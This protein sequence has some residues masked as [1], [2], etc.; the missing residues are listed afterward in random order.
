[1][2]EQSNKP[3]HIVQ[4]ETISHHAFPVSPDSLH[5]GFFR[6]LILCHTGLI[7]EISRIICPTPDGSCGIQTHD[8]WI[9]RLAATHCAIVVYSKHIYVCM[10]LYHTTSCC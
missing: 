2:K 9:L 7:W 10:G 8:S 1:M 3:N 6:W 5:V 4:I